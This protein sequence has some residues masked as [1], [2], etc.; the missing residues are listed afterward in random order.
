MKQDYL[1]YKKKRLTEIEEI[2][3]PMSGK[4]KYR[5][6]G[7]A[8]FIGFFIFTMIMPS[9]YRWTRLGMPLLHIM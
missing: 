9:G 7:V 1:A 6:L 3:K 2:E 5:A 4:R 8:V